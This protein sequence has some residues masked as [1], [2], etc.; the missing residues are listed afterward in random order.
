MTQMVAV[1]EESLRSRPSG[2]TLNRSRIRPP[3][4]T[5]MVA[6]YFRWDLFEILEAVE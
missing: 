2:H 5:T 6:V 3:E 4:A 1:R